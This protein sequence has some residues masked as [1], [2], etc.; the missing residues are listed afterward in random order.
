M[1]ENNYI[2]LN[3]N[4]IIKEIDKEINIL[5]YDKNTI[6]KNEE[7]KKSNNIIYPKCGEICMI[8]I[9]N[10][11]IK[12][13]KCKNNHEINNILLNEYEDTQNI[14][15]NKI[16]CNNC[17][18][19][20]NRIYNNELYICG[21]CKINLCP[22]CKLKHYKEHKII[23]YKNKNYIYNKHNEAFISYCKK[24]INNLCMI[25]EIEENN[26]EIISYK[27]IILKKDN[28]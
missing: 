25:C 26:H 28:N 15:E 19:N 5:V 4:K 20:K 27:G 1:E 12:L 13:N 22:L 8:K 18:I 6:I 17:K 16:I 14:N 21:E 3:I 7:I 10:Y 2:K 24:C 9:D 11:K 23:E